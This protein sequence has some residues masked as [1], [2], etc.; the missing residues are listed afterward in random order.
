MKFLAISA[1]N[2]DEFFMV[3]VATLLK[4]FRA[5]IDDPSI[6]GLSTDEELE[7]S[8]SRAGEQMAEQTRV[9]DGGAAAAAGRPKASA[10]STPPTTPRRST[11]G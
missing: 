10:S 9:L 11:P 6:D 8:A 5:G 2:L 1:T 4:K 3:R 7:S